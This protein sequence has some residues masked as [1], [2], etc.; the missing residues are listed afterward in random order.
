MPNIFQIVFFLK[1]NSTISFPLDWNMTLRTLT[2]WVD[3]MRSKND[4]LNKVM[5]LPIIIL[6]L[7]LNRCFRNLEGN[8]CVH[9]EDFKPFENYSW[10]EQL[11]AL[12][13]LR[14]ETHN[15]NDWDKYF[16]LVVEVVEYV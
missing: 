12:F 15:W 7:L 3:K 13:K 8:S 6:F 1:A 9:I 16:I 14:I 2:L 11:Q 4:D 10:V 5:G